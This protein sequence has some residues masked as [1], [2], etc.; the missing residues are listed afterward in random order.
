MFYINALTLMDTLYDETCP[1]QTKIIKFINAAKCCFARNSTKGK[2]SKKQ[3]K[4]V[5]YIPQNKQ[6]WH[7]VSS[8]K[9]K[10]TANNR[11][12]HQPVATSCKDRS[13]TPPPHEHGSTCY[14]IFSQNIYTAQ[15]KDNNS[16]QIDT[17]S[18]TSKLI[19]QH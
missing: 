14:R 19:T 9:Q 10:D 15:Q 6:P 7:T 5:V 11:Q 16:F 18:T 13:P 3:I 17:I 2:K 4:K 8:S 12:S 1:P